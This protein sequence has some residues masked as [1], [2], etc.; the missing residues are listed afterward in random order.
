MKKRGWMSKRKRGIR[1]TAGG[2]EKQVKEKSQGFQVFCHCIKKKD[3]HKENFL[4]M[5][6]KIIY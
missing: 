3:K 1:K 5:C 2:G 6:Y 4:P